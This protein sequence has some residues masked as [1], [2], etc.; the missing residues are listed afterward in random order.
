M[1][2]ETSYFD[3][4]YE[5]DADPWQ[6]RTRP[7][8]ARKREI[9][10]AAL[11]ERHYCTCFEPGCSIGVLTEAL[12]ARCDHVLAMD[13]AAE[14]LRL[15]SQQLPENVVLQRGAVPADW[16]DGTFELIVLSEVAYYLDKDDCALLASRATATELDLLA[17][18]WRHPVAEYP[19]SGDEAH[20][21]LHE[22]ARAAGMHHLVAHR[23]DD[24]RLDV[25]S[26]DTRSVAERTGV[27]HQ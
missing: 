13:T 11:P 17:I 18:H 16:P 10:L 19:I 7:Y 27:P 3:R 26:H 21:L 6:F 5:A 22:A 15:A 14:A 20:D 24:L 9:T 25:W 12:A 23:E 1:T 2:L 8:E 4:L